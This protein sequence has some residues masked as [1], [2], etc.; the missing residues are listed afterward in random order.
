[1]FSLVQFAPSQWPVAK[2]PQPASANDREMSPTLLVSE[3]SYRN[4]LPCPTL[5][6]QPVIVVD[7]LPERWRSRQ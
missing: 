2:A 5:R 3:F 7:A 6:D 4:A 1:M